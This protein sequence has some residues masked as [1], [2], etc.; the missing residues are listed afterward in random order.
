MAAK[1]F[2]SSFIYGIDGTVVSGVQHVPVGKHVGL[3]LEVGNCG[4]TP[5][6]I[7]ARILVNGE[8][9]HTSSQSI[10]PGVK[11]TGGCGFHM[12][13]RDVTIDFYALSGTTID[14]HD[15]LIIKPGSEIGKCTQLVTVRKKGTPSVVVKG[16]QIEA[17][18]L[19]GTVLSTTTGTNGSIIFYLP[20]NEKYDIL[21][22]PSSGYTC[23]RTS[24]CEKRGVT[25]CSSEIELFL[26]GEA[27]YP[28]AARWKSID[29]GVWDGSQIVFKYE[30]E[31][32]DTEKLSS[33]KCRYEYKGFASWGTKSAEG[34][35]V[36]ACGPLTNT[37]RLWALSPGAQVEIQLNRF[38]SK[39]FVWQNNIDRET[40]TIPEKEV[41]VGNKITVTVGHSFDI[42][43]TNAIKCGEVVPLPVQIPPGQTAW[44]PKPIGYEVCKKNIPSNRIVEFTAA[45]RLVEGHHYVF[46]IYPITWI[47]QV[48]NNQVF[49][50]KG[51]KTG[52]IE[53]VTFIHKPICNLLGIP[54]ESEECKDEVGEF[55]DPIYA[56]NT[57]NKILYH[58]DMHGNPAEPEMLDYVILPMVFAGSLV[59]MPVGKGTKLLAQ[60]SGD[61]AKYANTAS[62]KLWLK[63]HQKAIHQLAAVGDSVNLRTFMDNFRI[64]NLPVC[65]S[66]L[67]QAAEVAGRSESSRKLMR[68]N[69]KKWVIGLRAKW[70]T[71]PSLKTKI[72]DLEKGADG[73]VFKS[74]ESTI[75]SHFDDAAKA[76][77]WKKAHEIYHSAAMSVDDLAYLEH[78]LA[79]FSPDFRRMH[80]IM[81]YGNDDFIKF[82]KTDKA[83]VPEFAN[84]FDEGVEFIIRHIGEETGQ[85]VGAY[86]VILDALPESEVIAITRNLRGAGKSA[87]A[88]VTHVLKADATRGMGVF[89][90]TAAKGIKVTKKLSRKEQ[91]AVAAS[92]KTKIDDA[93][94]TMTP[95]EKAAVEGML[96]TDDPIKQP[97]LARLWKYIRGE[98]SA[99]KFRDFPLWKKAAV[100]GGAFIVVDMVWK[101]MMD[102]CMALF[103]GE[104]TIQWV[105]FG[106]IVL[107]ALT[108]DWDEKPLSER[109]KLIEIFTTFRD[110]RQMIH[111]VV[112][113]TSTIFETLCLPFAKIYQT[114][115]DAD[116]IS[117]EAL[118]TKI[119]FMEDGIDPLSGLGECTLIAQADKKGVAF[120][121]HGET[122]KY[123]SGAA[124]SKVYVPGVIVRDGSYEVVLC[125]E[126][127]G[128]VSPLM[129]KI[130]ITEND[131]DAR[132][133]T[134]LF[135]MVPDTEAGPDPFQG[136]PY[137]DAEYNALATKPEGVRRGKI[138]C[139]TSPAGAKIYL[140]GVYKNALTNWT[141]EYVPIGKHTVVFKKDGYAD[142]TVNVTVA[143]EPDAQAY[144]NFEG[145]EGAITF[146]CAHN[147]DYC[148]RGATIYYRKKGASIWETFGEKTSSYP[149]TK[150]G[151][152]AGVYEVRYTL[153]NVMGCQGEV[154]VKPGET[155]EFAMQLRSLLPTTV[156]TKVTAI[157]D[158]DGIRT[159]YTDDTGKFPPPS[160]KFKHQE[161]RIVGYNAPECEDYPTICAPGGKEAGD[162]LK[163]LIPV[164]TEIELRIF[165]WLPLGYNN[166]IIAG[167]FKNGKDIAKI[168]LSS[169]LV[170]LVASK[171]FTD[172]YPWV[173]WQG[174]D[175]YEAAWCN[176]NETNVTISTY[177]K[178]G[179]SMNVD[180]IL[181]DNDMKS[182]AEGGVTIK[183]VAPGT[184]TIEIQ[185][186]MLKGEGSESIPSYVEPLNQSFAPCVFDINV[187][188][189]KTYRVK[190]RLGV[191]AGELVTNTREI[192]FST[193]PIYAMIMIDGK[194]HVHP[195]ATTAKIPIKLGEHHSVAFTA[196]DYEPLNAE[197][198]VSPEKITCLTPSVCG[199]KNE[200]P[201]IL[202]A[203]SYVRVFLKSLVTA[204]S[205]LY[206]MQMKGG[207]EGIGL[208]EI[209][210]IVL[211]YKG[212]K[213][214]GFTPTL[215]NLIDVVRYFKGNR[216]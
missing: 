74:F 100:I 61:L 171:Y 44:I 117:I 85:E 72:D 23:E 212:K 211:A 101:R 172:K 175:S 35:Y 134:P 200:K 43:K 62:K 183:N 156:R 130:R 148:T 147:D 65:E 56:Y 115:W 77:D 119:E 82:L 10:Y 141:L 132:K 108:Y 93:A 58:R 165:E 37:I 177:D 154:T 194:S 155:V 178:Y 142:C 163:E 40:V 112:V 103:M 133:S 75:S 106:G 176:P 202:V 168:M 17:R 118:T 94:K 145:T 51:V 199:Y 162:R 71:T 107:N 167:V 39:N 157:V 143:V 120:Y 125:A 25:A 70:K 96:K 160:P 206:W 181:F 153:L 57:L 189:G 121:V 9:C 15:S 42:S 67:K 38:D 124:F 79:K 22:S 73:N 97:K 45:D 188:P 91:K 29:G 210:E 122:K 138:I 99:Q 104:E 88:A 20:K 216:P 60:L 114:F 129:Q 54:P 135:N 24:D 161:I 16:V 84:R 158:G 180:V 26:T 12:G 139:A 174:R 214:L 123:Y 204:R 151:L 80:N 149:P 116:T 186:D 89:Y 64:G 128:Y 1:G 208:D 33:G 21:I 69:L 49:E 201:Y 30:I 83:A 190:V 207:G 169:C 146:K 187:Q 166:R 136:L 95:K 68:T 159:A 102:F 198:I 14:A 5:G 170:E 19:S 87:A 182:S 179:E 18:P 126:K 4:T 3:I 109:R 31:N 76:G 7:T 184:H 144:C 41:P 209:I 8:A 36:S 92:L 13:T 50:F 86:K 78:N 196:T 2:I 192:T 213:D 63:M 191:M 48:L 59:P 193:S 197:I 66:I 111:D 105:G 47:D 90:E 52:T 34:F 81:R 140:D 137:T 55:I 150:G 28:G 131:L 173:T 6:T 185:D 11:F 110:N 46:T 27:E 164:G 113:N 98:D 203:E 53:N 32:P 205:F 152:E 195:G 215:D 127:D